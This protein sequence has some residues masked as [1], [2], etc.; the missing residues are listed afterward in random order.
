M[1]FFL[2]CV[3]FYDKFSKV[4]IEVPYTECFNALHA[5][6]TLCFPYTHSPVR[7]LIGVDRYAL[8]S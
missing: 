1:F 4:F 6:F 8:V 3:H 7:C 5:L 2:Q